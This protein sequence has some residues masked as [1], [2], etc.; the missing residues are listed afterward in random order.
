MRLSGATRVGAVKENRLD[1]KERKGFAMLK[2]LAGNT[3][4][5]PW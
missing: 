1:R 4:Q 3:S 2:F 5:N